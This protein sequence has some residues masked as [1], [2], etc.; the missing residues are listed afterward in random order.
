ME[1]L[2][3]FVE[4][5]DKHI[6]ITDE[7]KHDMSLYNGIDVEKEVNLAIEREYRDYLAAN[8]Q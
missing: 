8:Q 2:L 1:E 4:F 5:K 7:A 3:S 6:T